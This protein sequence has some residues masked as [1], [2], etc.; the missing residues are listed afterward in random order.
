MSR[1][2]LPDL[3]K[4]DL[5]T[6]KFHPNQRPDKIGGRFALKLNNNKSNTSSKANNYLS[7]SPNNSNY[8]S[9]NFSNIQ[10]TKI[11]HNKNRAQSYS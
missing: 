6:I 5:M 10:N 1:S 7:T 3:F 4:A 8:K 9:Q 11:T 2:T